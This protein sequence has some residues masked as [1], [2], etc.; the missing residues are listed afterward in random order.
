MIHHASHIPGHIHFDDSRLGK[1]HIHAQ[2]IKNR[3]L[4]YRALPEL[5]PDFIQPFSKLLVHL[6]ID[7]TAHQVDHMKP[8]RLLLVVHNPVAHTGIV[9]VEL[10][11]NLLEMP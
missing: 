3:T 7:M 2:E 4:V 8:N 10:E 11:P 6:R 5:H 1:I 9:G